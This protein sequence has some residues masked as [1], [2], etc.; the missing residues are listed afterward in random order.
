MID[1]DGGFDSYEHDEM[2]YTLALLDLRYE[3]Q[4]ARSLHPD[5]RSAHEGY[6]VI[7]EELDELWD[8][9]RTKQSERDLDAMRVE[10]IQIATTAIRFAAECC[11]E[12]GLH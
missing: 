4:R 12:T 2:P 11:R 8:H 5:L 3:L 1:D 7:L 10:A 6:A 9:V